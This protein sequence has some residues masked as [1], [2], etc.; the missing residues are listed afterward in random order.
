MSSSPQPVERPKIFSVIVKTHKIS[1]AQTVIIDTDDAEFDNAGCFQMFKNVAKEMSKDTAKVKKIVGCI[2]NGH[3]QC[4]RFDNALDVV[5]RYRPKS[6]TVYFE[7]NPG[8]GLNL[9]SIGSAINRR[10]RYSKPVWPHRRSCI[11]Q[12]SCEWENDSTSIG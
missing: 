8:E 12:R 3:E 9:R 1:F 6:V 11:C 2:V 5:T 4:L 7:E 10:I